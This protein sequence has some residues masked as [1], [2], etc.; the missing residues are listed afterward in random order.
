[1]VVHCL[2][3]SNLE[4]FPVPIVIFTFPERKMGP[5]ICAESVIPLSLSYDSSDAFVDVFIAIMLFYVC[6]DQGIHCCLASHIQV[7]LR[8]TPRARAHI[9]RNTALRQA[10]EAR[11]LFRSGRTCI[12]YGFMYPS[13]RDSATV[14]GA[15]H[16]QRGVYNT[17]I[18]AIGCRIGMEALSSP[19]SFAAT[20]ILW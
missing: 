9:L 11:K 17:T 6:H 8:G 1:M 20:A 19:L 5:N 18:R 4:C 10:H 12:A 7:V 13:P 3:G 14:K 15:H 2:H 16:G